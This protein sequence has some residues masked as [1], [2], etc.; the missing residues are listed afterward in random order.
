MRTAVASDP[1][2]DPGFALDPRPARSGKVLVRSQ[3]SAAARRRMSYGVAI[4][5]TSRTNVVRNT[6][7]T[8]GTR[9]DR[10]RAAAGFRA[11]RGRPLLHRLR[12]LP[13]PRSLSR[14]PAAV[15]PLL[16]AR[17]CAGILPANR[18]GA[19]RIAL[20]LAFLDGSAPRRGTPG[21]LRKAAGGEFLTQLDRAHMKRAIE[22][23]E[24]G[25]GHTSPNPL[26]GALVVRDDEVLGEGY[27]AAYGRPT[28]RSRR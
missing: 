18:P 3:K 17:R 5:P 22:L 4:V 8:E 26:V 14:G 9:V 15:G 24:L 13:A 21:Y 11:D 19:G 7:F 12:A 6:Y 25:R 1:S 10:R 2:G 16:A 20:R 28:P 27:H 23:A